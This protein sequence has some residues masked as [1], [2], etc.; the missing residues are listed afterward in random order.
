MN[1]IFWGLF[2]ILL[3][4]SL[5]CKAVFGWDLPILKVAFGCLLIYWGVQ[6]LFNTPRL[7]LFSRKKYGT[8]V[9]STVFGSNTV[10]LS[11]MTFDRPTHIT[12]NTAFGSTEIILDKDIPT[13]I[14]VASFAATVDLPQADLKMVNSQQYITRHGSSKPYLILMINAT[15]G[16]VIVKTR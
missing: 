11:K 7:S 15:F 12:S 9:Y 1:I 10:D 6:V 8:F 14:N 5:V 4:I 16:T 13:E 3:G 2:L